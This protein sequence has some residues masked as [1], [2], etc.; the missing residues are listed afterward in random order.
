MKSALTICQK[1]Q[2]P[3]P[4]AEVLARPVYST[5]T[6]S[7]ANGDLISYTEVVNVVPTATSP[8]AAVLCLL[9]TLLL[10]LVLR[11]V[12]LQLIHPISHLIFFECL[13]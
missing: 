3:P 5:F 2:P 6:T 13:T 9:E 1:F 12:A 7:D 4:S 8:S 10:G 11:L